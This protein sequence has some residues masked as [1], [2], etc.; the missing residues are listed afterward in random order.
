MRSRVERL[1]PGEPVWMS[2]FHRFCARLLR[3]YGAAGRAGGKLHDLRH[4]RQPAGAAPHARRDRRRRH[5]LHARADR[6]RHQ[7]GQEQPDHGRST[8]TPRPGSPLGNIVAR[9]YPAYQTAAAGV[10]RGR[11]RR[12]AVARGHAAARTVPKPAPRSTRAIA[13]SWSTNTRTRTWPNT[14]SCGP[15]RSTIRTWP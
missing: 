1:A 14:R 2:T 12:P 11:F 3:Q 4:L 13:T 15:C 6:G 7:L 9:V 8:T 10:E 5:A